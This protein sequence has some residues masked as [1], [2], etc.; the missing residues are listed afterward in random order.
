MK[1]KL[2]ENEI[3]ILID[4]SIDRIPFEIKKIKI[5]LFL[6]KL[7]NKQKIKKE[8]VLR[9]F[10]FIYIIFTLYYFLIN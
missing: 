9:L 8:Y 7:I 3:E 5:L 4:K 2:K 10:L 6:L 1:K